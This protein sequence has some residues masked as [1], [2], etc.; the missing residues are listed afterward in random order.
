MGCDGSVSVYD[1]DNVD[2]EHRK[3]YGFG[4]LDDWN[5]GN[6]AC[7][8]DLH[9]KKWILNYHDTNGLDNLDEFWCEDEDAY[10]RVRKTF[11]AVGATDETEVWT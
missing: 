5:Y 7:I 6:R 8:V 10:Q 1:F 11:N 9:G 3:S 4:L 2:E